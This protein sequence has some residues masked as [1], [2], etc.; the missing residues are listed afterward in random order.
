MSIYAMVSNETVIDIILNV[1]EPPSWPIEASGYPVEAVECDNSV[2]IG[3][4]YDRT[5]SAFFEAEPEK[6]P[7]EPTPEP[8]QLDRIE[9]TL[10][11]LTADTVTAESIDTAISE[12]VNEV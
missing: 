11:I 2:T 7:P 1:V 12:G 6:T 10:A 9:S 4:K 5:T 3:M 8:T